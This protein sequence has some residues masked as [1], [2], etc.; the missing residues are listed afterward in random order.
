MSDMVCTCFVVLL[1]FHMFRC[2]IW[3]VHDPG[4]LRNA[5]GVLRNGIGVLRNVPGV[6]HNILGMLHNVPDVVQFP[7]CVAQ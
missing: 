5:L 4:V 3:F 6:L 7:G 1:R 2:Q